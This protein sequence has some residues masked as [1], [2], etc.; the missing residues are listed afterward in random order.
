MNPVTDAQ[1]KDYYKSIK[2]LL[3]ICRKEEKQFLS[4]LADSI[5]EFCA[6]RPDA[7]LDEIYERYGLP[8]QVVADYY[9]SMDYEDLEKRISFSTMLKRLCAFIVILVL[10]FFSVRTILLYRSYQKSN[11]AT[12]TEKVIV[13]E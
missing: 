4:A 11:E 8:N 9:T 7:T 13:I 10:L 3:P 12:I 6:C 1:L 2:C 5:E